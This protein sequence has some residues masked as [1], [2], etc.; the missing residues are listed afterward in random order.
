[1]IMHQAS[2]KWLSPPHGDG[3]AQLVAEVFSLLPHVE[4]DESVGCEGLFLQLVAEVFSFL[5]GRKLC[6]FL[7][8][9][10]PKTSLTSSPVRVSRSI[11]TCR[12]EARAESALEG[13]PSDRYSTAP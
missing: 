9:G 10:R 12:A 6:V 13:A 8:G 1:M 3:E 11:R 7:S 5:S 2:R 4:S